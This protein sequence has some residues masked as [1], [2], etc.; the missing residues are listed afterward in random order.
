MQARISSSKSIW[1]TGGNLQNQPEEMLRLFLA[2]AGG[3]YISIDEAQAENRV[4]AYEAQEAR[5]IEALEAG[6]DIHSLTGS[7]IHSIPTAQVT[8]AQRDD[9]KVA[10]HGL[11]Y[12][13]GVENFTLR[14]ALERERGKFI[15]SRYHSVYPGVHEWHER[16][17]EELSRNN[18]VLTN[19]YGRSRRFLDA[20]GADLFEKAYN[21]RPQSTIATKMNNDGVRFVY[22]HQDLFPDVHF[23]NTVHDSLWLW[24]P[25]K[26]GV[27]RVVEVAMMV[28]RSLEQP[29]TIN[30]RTFQ[31]PADIKVGFNLF[32]KDMLS[33]KASSDLSNTKGLEEELDLYVRKA[34]R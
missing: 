10:N 18:R 21:Y 14:Y 27:G 3:I 20:W 11:N 30:G 34:S 31:I 7:L 5:M 15:W 29:L 9:G 1:G 22:E 25:L 6:I 33:W 16:I 2:D 17:K 24:V 23:A 13:L 4:V 8:K 32:E 19:C 26:Q 28:K 12:A